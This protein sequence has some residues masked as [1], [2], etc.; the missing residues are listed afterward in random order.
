MANKT[1]PSRIELRRSSAA[2]LLTGV[3][4]LSVVVL[5]R[6][7]SGAATGFSSATAA[8]IVS[9]AVMLVGLLSGL[10]LQRERRAADFAQDLMLSALSTLPG[11]VLGLAL[12][13]TSEATGLAAL[14]GEFLILIASSTQMVSS[15]SGAAVVPARSETK[16]TVESASSIG[17]ALQVTAASAHATSMTREVAE[18]EAQPMPLDSDVAI[19]T[20]S[21]AVLAMTGEPS[22]GRFDDVSEEDAELDS[23]RTQWM[24]RRVCEGCDIIEGRLRVTL[25]P[26]AKQVAVHVPFAPAF[27]MTPE[28][29]AEPLDDCEVEVQCSSLHSYGVRFEVS[30]RQ[31]LSDELTLEIGYCASASLIESAAA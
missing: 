17:D 18:S 29:E 2:G 8:C 28:F 26:G 3:L 9:G 19:L 7:A 16:E 31:Q 10:T 6:R 24:R 11:L 25:P 21:T 5:S 13:P 12:M 4:L 22:D 23:Q 30:R 27:S 20:E 1:L 15:M 14:L